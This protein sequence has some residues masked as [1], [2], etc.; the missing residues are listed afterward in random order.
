MHYHIWT[1]IDLNTMDRDPWRYQTR[2]AA[3]KYSRRHSGGQQ[4]MVLQCDRILGL[5]P[6]QR[7]EVYEQ[8]LMLAEDIVMRRGLWHAARSALETAAARLTELVIKQAAAKEF[9]DDYVT[10]VFRDDRE[11]I[12]RLLFRYIREAMVNSPGF[13][14]G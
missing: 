7:E 4:T 10:A 2:S 6:R 14:F 13:P 8:A 1:R 12:E 5:S 9:G 3:A 11:T